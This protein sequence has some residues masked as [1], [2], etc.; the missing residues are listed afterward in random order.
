MSICWGPMQAAIQSSVSAVK[1]SLSAVQGAASSMKLERTSQLQWQMAIMQQVLQASSNVVE[2]C[3]ST[4][5][6]AIGNMNR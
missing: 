5:K 3:L 6:V 4:A 1:T 2:G